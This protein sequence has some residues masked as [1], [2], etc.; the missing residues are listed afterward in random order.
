MAG[1][2]WEIFEGT[3]KIKEFEQKETKEVSGMAALKVRTGDSARPRIII[4][5]RLGEEKF[6]E[7]VM[8]SSFS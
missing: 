8:V 1:C 4:L 2:S 6:E 7:T 5:E 3:G